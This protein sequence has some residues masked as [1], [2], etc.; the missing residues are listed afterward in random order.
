MKFVLFFTI[1]FIN[2]DENEKI[3]EALFSLSLTQKDLSYDKLWIKE[4][5]FMTSV[6]KDIMKNPLSLPSY[7]EKTDSILGSNLDNYTFVVEYFMNQL[8]IKKCDIKISF[9]NISFSE[10]PFKDLNKLLSKYMLYIKNYNNFLKNVISEFSPEE[11]DSLLIY[12]P[13]LFEDEDDKSDD[14][15]KGILHRE[16]GIKVDTSFN[17]KGSKLFEKIYKIRYEQILCYNLEILKIME[18]IY[19]TSIKIYEKNSEYKKIIETDYG[20]IAINF[21]KEDNVYE[22]KYILIIDGGGNDLY[23][24]NTTRATGFGKFNPFNIIIDFEGND[25]YTGKRVFSIASGFFGAGVIFDLKGDD[26]YKGGYYSIGS[27]FFGT[28]ILFDKEGDDTYQSKVFSQGSA[29]FGTGVLIDLEGND[30]YRLWNYGQGFASTKGYGILYDKKGSDSYI[31]YGKFIHHPLLPSETRSFA[32]GFS[33]GW[34]PY[35]SGGIGVLIDEEGNDLYYSEVYGQGTSYFYSIGMLLDKK[36]N[37]LYSASEYAQGSG[38]HLSAGILVDLEGHDDYI[39]RYGPAQGEGHDLSVGILIDKKGDDFYKVS[40]GQGI[41]LTNSIGIFIDSDGNDVYTTWEKKL[42]QGSGTWAR[43]FCGIGIFLD[44]KGKDLYPLKDY[45]ENLSIQVKGKYGVKIDPDTTKVIYPEEEGKDF[46]IPA[47]IDIREL[48]KIASEWGVRENKKKVRKAREMLAKRGEESLKYIFQEKINTIK[49]LEIR[50][51]TEVIKKNKEKS[52]PY[53]LKAMHSENDTVRKN[54]I[55]L[56]GKI[57]IEKLADSIGNLLLEEVNEKVKSVI[58]YALGRIKNKNFV[59][60][61]K[62][63][64]NKSHE[65]FLK[66][67]ICEYFQKVKD[68]S[69]IDFLTEVIKKEIGAIR[70]AAESALVYQGEKAEAKVVEKIEKIKDPVIL[71]HF[72]RILPQVSSSIQVKKTLLKYLNSPS[73]LLRGISARGLGKIG[74]KGIKNLLELKIETEDNIFVRKEIEKVLKN[75]GL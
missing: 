61:I 32:Q 56:T 30:T 31:A 66:I 29:F 43:G 68:T 60:E 58:I 75:Q 35:A 4:D 45:K 74:G 46:E 62:N 55:Y 49:T 53:L 59:E 24:G 3:K 47:T 69:S 25:V 26:F 16:R 72:L 14:T 63:T 19:R 50:A 11:F 27:G 1:F 36:G 67:S 9:E 12:L 15:L 40:G 71:S 18:Q 21:T 28:G 41:G 2:Q 37:D 39:S 42:G 52:I 20:K 57:K 13:C 51:I 38:I 34:R 5:K 70:Y 22:G 44:L 8:D 73:W 65:E 6:F 7:L 17:I 48:F 54:A 23:R 33:I 10:T 64:F